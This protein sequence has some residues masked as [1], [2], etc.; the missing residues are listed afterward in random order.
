VGPARRTPEMAVSRRRRVPPRAVVLA[1]AVAVVCLVVVIVCLVIA[2]EAVRAAADGTT[3]S[4]GVLGLPLFVGFHEGGR[5]GVHGEWRLA[6][7]AVLPVA[8][9]VVAV[10]AGRIRRPSQR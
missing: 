4:A 3:A 1:P 10:L 8:A 7:L 9:A 2:S 6:V 5:V